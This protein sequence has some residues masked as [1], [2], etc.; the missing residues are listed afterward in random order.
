MR[1]IPATLNSK[2]RLAGPGDGDV[3]EMTGLL[4]GEVCGQLPAGAE[5]GGGE[6]SHPC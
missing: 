5:G 6:G 2:N 1:T 4:G 3:G